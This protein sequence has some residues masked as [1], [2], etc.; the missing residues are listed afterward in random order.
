MAYISIGQILY[1]PGSIFMSEDNISPSDLIG[2]TWL[3]WNAGYSP[4]QSGSYID[5][6]IFELGKS[7]GSATVTLT[8][9]TMPSHEHRVKR[10]TLNGG[11]S[12]HHVGSYRSS[13]GGGNLWWI[14]ADDGAGSSRYIAEAVG[15]GAAHENMP[16][17]KAINI[18]TRLS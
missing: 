3:Q 12:N 1:P 7:G 18:W 9:E 16:P 4:I 5:D 2:G 17:W 11:L 6:I 10:E 14:P 13:A 8:E 15:G